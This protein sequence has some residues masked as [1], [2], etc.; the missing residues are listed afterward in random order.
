[1]TRRK[2]SLLRGGFGLS[3]LIAAGAT[4]RDA[5]YMRR[6]RA[7]KAI[8]RALIS[9]KKG[10][11]LPSLRRRPFRWRPAQSKS[12]AV[13]SAS[14]SFARTE[15]RHPAGEAELTTI[16]NIAHTV[17]PIQ[18]RHHQYGCTCNAGKPTTASVAVIV[19]RLS[20]SEIR[21]VRCT[22]QNWTLRVNRPV[23]ISGPRR[24]GDDLP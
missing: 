10:D 5:R 23:T 14:C 7:P 24:D 8:R 12:P 19:N 4:F 15:G 21:S 22:P 2:S 18:H 16:A 11:R 20:A 6:S 13:A 17:E 1:M 3:S 9:I